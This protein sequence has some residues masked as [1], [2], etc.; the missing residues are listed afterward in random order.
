MNSLLMTFYILSSIVIL[1]LAWTYK[2]LLRAKTPER[3]LYFLPI[4]MALITVPIYTLF[5]SSKTYFYAMLFDA[6]YFACTDWLCFCILVFALSFTW[7][8]FAIKPVTLIALPLLAL[9]TSSL[10]VNTWT[11]HSFNLTPDV[12]ANG[13]AYWSCQFTPLHY[14]HLAFCYVMF[15]SALCLFVHAIVT[16]PTGYKAKHV[17]VFSASIVVIISNAIC[18]SL[19]LAVDFSVLLYPLFGIFVYYYTIYLAT[20]SLLTRSLISVNENIDDAILYFDVNEDCIY[21]NSRANDLFTV[22]GE[23]S[24]RKARRFLISA[25]GKNQAKN[26]AAPVEFFTVGGQERQFEIEAEDIYY[27]YSLIGSYL[28]LSDKT[29]E[30][31]RYL[32][33]KFLANHD[34]LTGAYTREY[35]FKMCDEKIKQNPNTE[36]LMLSSNIRQFKLVNELFGEEVGNKILIKMVTTAKT[37]AIHDCV[38]GRVGD[39]RFGVLAQKQYFTEEHIK[40]FLESSQE[41]LEG[42]NYTLN[43][44]VGVCEVHGSEESAQVIYDKTQL[45]IKKICDDYQKHLAWYD[46]DMMD[47]LLRERQIITEFDDALRNGQICMYLQPYFDRDGKAFGGEALARW[48]HP[49]RGILQ[50]EVFLQPLEKSGLIHKLDTFIWDKAAQ[51]LEEWSKRGIDNMQISVNVSAKDMFYIDIADSFKQMLLKRTFNPQNLKIEFTEEAL[52]ADLNAAVRLF[53]KLKKLGFEV[54][55]DDFGHGY[56]SLNFLKD[57]NAD[58]LK[59]D[60]V[61]IQ[62]NENTERAK[63]ILKFIVQISKAL[64]MKLISEGVETAEQLSTLKELGFPY[65]QGFFFSKPIA[66]NE[67]EEKYL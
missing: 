15:F 63:I 25:R 29:D 32:T 36:Y 16:A 21:K 23:F 59:L 9:D 53:E 24:N 13:T 65:F 49:Q 20:R 62:K 11:R 46:S 30:I 50:P 34:E 31:N 8:R 5:I 48:N 64:G 3:N 4:G 35:F 43:L 12:L 38:L 28:K 54:G 18:Y 14:L 7:R 66:I 27:G 6:L 22:D 33:Q 2:S 55:I 42:S 1:L 39:D 47:E 61:L 19:D 56:S 52:N 40:S 17:A 60:M 10:I 57:V 37:L 58:I 51:T 44:C 45:A 41:V 67:F 26:E